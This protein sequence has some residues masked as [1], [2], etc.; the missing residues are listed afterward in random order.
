[1]MGHLPIYS[2]NVR[3][4]P[5]VTFDQQGIKRGGPVLSS[6]QSPNLSCLDFYFW[7]HVKTLA[8][9]TPDGN[10]EELVPRIAVADAGNSKYA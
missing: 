5:D 7:G 4:Y 1:M 8:F 2:Q 6:V 9:D 3:N 10:A